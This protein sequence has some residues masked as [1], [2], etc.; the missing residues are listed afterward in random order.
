MHFNGTAGSRI[1]AL[2]A[3]QSG[4]SSPP[5][6]AISHGI[7]LSAA[8]FMPQTPRQGKKAPPM[9]YPRDR[10]AV[11]TTALMQVIF[12]SSLPWFDRRRH[13]E[14][15]LRD[16]IAAVQHEVIALSSDYW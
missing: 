11:V 2:E 16:E 14:A 15:Y 8:D 5:V 13:V 9:H 1:K 6:P 4:G 12:S 7:S 10:A 3:T